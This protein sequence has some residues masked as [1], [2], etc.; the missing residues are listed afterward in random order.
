ML[1]TNIP[2][3]ARNPGG[4]TQSQIEDA[5]RRK[6][7][8]AE[9]SFRYE[10]LDAENARLMDLDNVLDGQV[11]HNWLAPVKRTAQFRIRDTGVI[12]FLSDRI[13]PYARLWIPDLQLAAQT[14]EPTITQVQ[15]V[16]NESDGATAAPSISWTGSGGDL[17]TEGNLLVALIGGTGWTVGEA[18]EVSGWSTAVA[19]FG[20]PYGLIAFKIAG[21]NEA[22]TV[23]FGEETGVFA[24]MALME[25]HSDVAWPTECIDQSASGTESGSP[26]DSGTT[27]AT[28]EKVGVAIGLFASDDGDFTG[29]TYDNG[30][31]EETY[32]D[33][34]T[35]STDGAASVVSKEL[36]ALEAVNVSL[37]TTAGSTNMVGMVAAFTIPPL[38]L[39]VRVKERNYVEWPLGVFLLSTPTRVLDR[40]DVITRD[41]QGY[42]Q[43]Q[44]FLD[45]AVTDR[46]EVAASA[47]YVD[48][49][50]TLLGGVDAQA[51][52]SS[53]TLPAARD[54]DPGTPK[55]TIINDLLGSIN[56]HPLH[57][58]AE[59]L[60]I[61]A[62]YESPSD[63]PPEWTYTDLTASV[64]GYGA[65]QELDLFGIANK[66]V[67]VVSE[68]DQPIL[69]STY[70]N[71]DPASPTST[72]R[73][74]RTIVDFRTS[75][76][77]LGGGLDA[78]GEPIPP[79]QSALDD[80]VERLAFEA[81]QVYA[82][83]EFE[84]GLMPIHSGPDVFWITFD[85][86]A[87]NAKF[88]GHTWSLPL[89][90]GE[91]MSHRARRVV[92]I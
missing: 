49:V 23:T 62:P 42:D 5:L 24:H 44:V 31:E 78:E 39:A 43:L 67:V 68:P 12:N 60:A 53:L 20:D 70:T 4:Y 1:S 41:V 10:L 16:S 81:S 7:A 21:P 92:V 30:F 65:Q 36:D 61:I 80:F 57:F 8:K 50:E 18:I 77:G 69:S 19:A 85:R 90:G 33:T 88:S 25:Y 45:D 87:I 58:D 13:R 63:R 54:W 35:A 75:P 89:R 11:D 26:V 27:T 52:A 28:S 22:D 32:G 37:T 82:A 55:L 6:S 72:T 91:R 51:V 83:L 76:E 15:V 17:P 48:A 59:G 34:G 71:T 14:I 64:L 74:G 56:Y 46:Y 84:T 3:G 40:G 38:E 9:W 79:S 73:R 2:E 29:R 86:L 47:N 66:W